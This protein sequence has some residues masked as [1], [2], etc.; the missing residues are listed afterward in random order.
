MLG[1]TGYYIGDERVYS[2]TELYSCYFSKFLDL[3]CSTRNTCYLPILYSTEEL[4]SERAAKLH[5]TLS[6]R[7]K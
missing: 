5:H 3:L 2:N 1:K 6:C 7:T 4:T